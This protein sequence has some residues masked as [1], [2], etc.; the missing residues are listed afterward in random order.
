MFE[1]K[2]R[3]PMATLLESDPECFTIGEVILEK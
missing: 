3:D 1:K 2:L